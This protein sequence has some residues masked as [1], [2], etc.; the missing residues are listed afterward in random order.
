[1]SHHIIKIANIAEDILLVA[2]Y[3]FSSDQLWLWIFCQ[4]M[5]KFG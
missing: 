1:M 2:D 5:T 3:N 4:N